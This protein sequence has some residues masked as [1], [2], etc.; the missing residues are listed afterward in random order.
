[1]FV[2]LLFLKGINFVISVNFILNNMFVCFN[3][4]NALTSGVKGY[5]SRVLQYVLMLLQH[6]VLIV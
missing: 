2:V 6:F 3:D 5:K 1:M 4:N